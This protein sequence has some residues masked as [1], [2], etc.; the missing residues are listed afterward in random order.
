MKRK[1]HW[2]WKAYFFLYSTGILLNLLIFFSDESPIH[3]YYHILMIFK[4]SYCIQYY[5]YIAKVIIEALSLI[6]LFL[7]IFR[8]HAFPVLIWQF[9]FCSRIFLL[10]F[11]QSYE[12]NLFRA[13]IYG[14]PTATIA[15]LSLGILFAIPSYI[16]CSKYA[17][18]QKQL[19]SE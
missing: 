17:F 11:G 3:Q 9:L 15:A 12:W 10:I 6:P 1:T 8:I 19:L 16:A 7:F 14:N 5:L 18:W 13:M 2:T 4:Q